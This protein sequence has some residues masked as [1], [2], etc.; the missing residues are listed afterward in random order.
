MCDKSPNNF[1]AVKGPR[2][3]AVAHLPS[4]SHPAPAQPW[5][6]VL[7]KG[8]GLP[9]ASRAKGFAEPTVENNQRGGHPRFFYGM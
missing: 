3:Q 5:C 9:E 6:S 2:E 8:D 7:V 1:S 4:T